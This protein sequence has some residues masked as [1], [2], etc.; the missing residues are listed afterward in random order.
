MSAYRK[1]SDAPKSEFR[2][3]GSSKPAKA[4]KAAAAETPAL[5]DL[6]ALGGRCPEARNP[7]L[8]GDAPFRGPENAPRWA[9][10]EEER[11]AI[12]EHD[13]ARMDPAPECVPPLLLR[14]GRRLHSFPARNIPA[15]A[16]DDVVTS[17][18]D[19]SRHLGAVLV[20]DGMTL[21][22][23]EPRRGLPP[24]LLAEFCRRAG[25]IIAALRGEHRRRTDETP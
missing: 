10:I 6:G 8:G 18:V 22:L 20:A 25:A 3:S 24:Q 23:V 19:R 21:V 11:A 16:D 12:I 4:P 17:L 15:T 5:G 2:T 7:V 13:V 9:K 14:D 1:F